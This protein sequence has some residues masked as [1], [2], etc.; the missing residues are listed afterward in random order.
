MNCTSA[1]GLL[2]AYLDNELD[3]AQQA[4]IAAH[5]ESCA[6]C[7][8]SLDRLKQLSAAI[9]N[10]EFEYQP[11]AY[12]EAR[13]RGALRESARPERRN[14]AFW[15]WAA[16]AACLILAAVLAWRLVQLR[17]RD[18]NR[19]VIAREV[20]SSHVRS[21]LGNHLLDVPSTDRH[22]VKPWFD[23]KLDFSPDV[24]DL[25]SRGFPLTGGRLDYVDNRP[26]AALVFQRRL[27]MINLFVW[28]SS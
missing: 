12:F 20:V 15:R 8:A 28:P 3:A 4:E 6:S 16:L 14:Y 13:V 2:E 27:H 26:V 25:S 7:A 19:Q 23:G 21:L 5:L 24:K 1:K 22:T 10:P 11:P 17:S 18:S 9:R